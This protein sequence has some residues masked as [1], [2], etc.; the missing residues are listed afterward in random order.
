MRPTRTTQRQ[1]KQWCK[2]KKLDKLL[3]YCENNHFYVQRVLN[4]EMN[5]RFKLHFVER[6][7]E[8]VPWQFSKLTD[9][10]K[11]NAIVLN[12]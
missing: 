12:F 5:R 7:R 4:L 11:T 8:I 1:L 9:Y 3:H 10:S 6:L 2:Q